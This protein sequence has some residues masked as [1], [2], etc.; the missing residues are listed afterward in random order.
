[1]SKKLTFFSSIIL[2]L[3][4]YSSLCQARTFVKVP[5]TGIIMKVVAAFDNISATSKRG[6]GK[7]VFYKMGMLKP[8][9]VM[10]EDHLYYKISDQQNDSGK[11]GYVLKA[12]TRQWNT[13]EGLR[14]IP[15]LLRSE[16]HTSELQSP[17]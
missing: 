5:G 6:I 4:V 2:A 15:S 8:Y 16:E 14:F 11:V 9:F 12:H 13:R 7:A 1:M 3:T 17:E 10:A